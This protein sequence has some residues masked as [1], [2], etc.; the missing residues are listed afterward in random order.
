MV[1]GFIAGGDKALRSAVEGCEDSREQGVETVEKAAVTEKDVVVGITAS[2][3]AS[4]VLA[5]LE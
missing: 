1:Q 5:S 4:Y 3:S 2:G